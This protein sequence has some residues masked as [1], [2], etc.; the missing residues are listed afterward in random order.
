MFIS[1]DGGN[2]WRQVTERFWDRG[3]IFRANLANISLIYGILSLIVTFCLFK[4]K[5]LKQLFCLVNVAGRIDGQWGKMGRA[6]QGIRRTRVSL[7][8]SFFHS[9]IGMKQLP[10]ANSHSCVR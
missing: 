9:T 6:G 4:K 1:S 3:E 2:T 5:K 10:D 8:C 7:V